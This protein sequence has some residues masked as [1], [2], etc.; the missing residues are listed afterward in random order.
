MWPH[1]HCELQLLRVSLDPE[2]LR[3]KRAQR[4]KSHKESGSKSG[5]R[6][7]QQRISELMSA[8][9]NGRHL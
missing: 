6:G 3:A 5:L 4:L 9:G 7:G 1:Q 2:G 8:D